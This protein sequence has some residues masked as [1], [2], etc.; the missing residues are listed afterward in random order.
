M[1]SETFPMTK[2]TSNIEE[3]LQLFVTE[4]KKNQRVWGLRNNDEDWLAC[5]S[6][7]FENSEV[8]PFWSNKED[9]AIHNIEEWAEFEI[10]E[11]PLDVFVEDWLITLSEDGVLAG[12]NWNQSLEG[13]EME[14]S[15]LATLFI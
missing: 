2:L 14:P 4:T 1:N 11:I 9:A 6:S 12:I 5:D 15:D 8:M 13:K 10:C 7:E 3:N